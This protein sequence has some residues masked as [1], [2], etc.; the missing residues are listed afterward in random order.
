MAYP[1]ADSP[2][3]GLDDFVEAYEAAQ[4][5]EGEADLG[6]FLPATEH[7]LYPEVLR[8]LVRVDLEFGWKRG[9][10]RRLEEYLRLYP[11]LARDASG[12]QEAAFEEY[13]LRRQA[14][15]KV[16]RA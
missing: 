1:T 12:V 6:R 10:P 15:L 8:E 9:R 16:T 14:G 7:P 11:E 3:A 5:R 4:A 13:R 2:E